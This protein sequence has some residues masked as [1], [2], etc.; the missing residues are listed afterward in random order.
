MVNVVYK[1]VNVNVK[2]ATFYIFASTANSFECSASYQNGAMQVGR[3]CVWHQCF[4]I[5]ACSPALIIAKLF[6]FRALRQRMQF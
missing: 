1:F 4:L 6:F 5:A 3:R 2:Q